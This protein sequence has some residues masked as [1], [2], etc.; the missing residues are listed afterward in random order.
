MLVLPLAMIATSGAPAQVTISPTTVSFGSV[1]TGLTSSVHTVTLTN[2]GTTSV[3]VTSLSVSA[4]FHLTSGQYLVVTGIKAD[5]K[6]TYRFF[7]S[8][9]AAQSYS[10]TATFTVSGQTYSTT[11]SGI[12]VSTAASASI[13]PTALNFGSVVVGSTSTQ[14]VTVTNTGTATLNITAIGTVPPFS[15]GGFTSTVTLD[16]GQ[17]FTFQVSY[18]A[19]STT[20]ITGT[21]TLTYDVLPS[22]GVSLS[23][24]G[25]TPTKLAVSSYPTLP[26][27]VQGDTYLASLLTIG[28]KSPYHWKTVSGTLPS[29]L[30]L[31]STGTI[32]G[33]V[34]STVAVG[35][36][37]FTVSV[38]DNSS[39]RMT[40]RASITIPMA[41]PSGLGNCN[42]IEFDVPGTT[43]PIVALNDLGTGTYLGYEGGLY[44][45]G[46][47]VD[48]S[49]HLAAGES[50]AAG[51][52]PLDANG[53]PDPANGVEVLLAIGVSITDL[54]WSVFETNANADPAKNPKVVLVDGADGGEDASQL[55]S[56]AS[57][58]WTQIL[59]YWVPGAGV[60]TNQVV[61]VWVNNVDSA[62]P[63]FPADATNL[64]SEYESIAQNI[65]TLFPNAVLAYFSSIPYTG[66]SNGVD[67]TDP[68]PGGYE[69]GFGVQLAIAD[70]INGDPNLNFDPS[71]GTVKAPWMAW[72]PY[73]WANGLLARSDGTTWDC[74]D[75]ADDGLHPFRTT[76]RPKIA[77]FLLNF[78][79]ADPTASPWFLA[80][81]L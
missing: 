80:P 67:P 39:P 11:F 53:T 57:P 13:N 68:E 32:S 27:A 17:S 34:S 52:Q 46:S 8:P 71:L 5:K 76:G 58:Y 40:A 47:N 14:N 2:T 56:T 36:Y 1:Y 26:S 41:S 19:T 75:Y 61:G 81:A 22:G 79:K 54:S 43:T 28:G 70:Q 31:S 30:T 65:H 73:L 59:D 63:S 55:V 78:F 38:I 62:P 25:T 23:G 4:P 72:G 37:T 44:P 9:T 12:G 42:D 21:A 66:Y 74:V 49:G 33:T 7:F 48:P 69:G 50:I 20:S 15:V 45:G 24:A 51:I 35:N 16:A 10:S 6:A 60:T 64:E 77:A 29:G 3:S 18:F